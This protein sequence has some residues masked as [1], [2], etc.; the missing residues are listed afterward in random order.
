MWPKGGS[1]GL[2]DATEDTPPLPLAALGP[3]LLG[4][5][6]GS[7]AGLLVHTIRHAFG[8]NTLHRPQRSR[9]V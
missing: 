6:L 1:L 2:L 9:S 5:G 4:D 8:S 7:L 3:L